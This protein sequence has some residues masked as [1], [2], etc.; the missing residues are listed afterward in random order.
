MRF[1]SKTILDSIRCA[2]LCLWAPTV[3][4]ITISIEIKSLWLAKTLDYHEKK[5]LLL[6]VRFM[7]K[8]LAPNS[9]FWKAIIS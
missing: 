6:R 4:I 5:Y 8:K 9:R 2:S 1:V 7:K 3:R